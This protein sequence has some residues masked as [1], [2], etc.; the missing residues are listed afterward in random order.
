M[1]TAAAAAAAAAAATKTA[2]FRCAA[3]DK[4]D[5]YHRYCLVSLRSPRQSSIVV[6]IITNIHACMHLILI[7]THYCLTALRAYSL[8]TIR[9]PY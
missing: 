4:N 5:K 6:C 2:S 1:I 7:N 9:R 8:T 3:F